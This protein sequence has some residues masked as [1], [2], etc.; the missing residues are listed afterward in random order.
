[1]KIFQFKRSDHIDP[2]ECAN[3]CTSNEVQNLIITWSNLPAKKCLFGDPSKH[4][5]IL[6]K[7][8]VVHGFQTIYTCGF[9]GEHYDKDEETQVQTWTTSLVIHVLVACSLYYLLKIHTSKV[10]Y[11]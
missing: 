11:A 5:H 2:L 1:M 8:R 3:Y 4:I 9:I 7:S 6:N 10:G